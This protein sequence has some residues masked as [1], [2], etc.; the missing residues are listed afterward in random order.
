LRISKIIARGK[1]IFV[2]SDLHIGDGTAKD[3][4]YFRKKHLLLQSFLDYVDGE[5][6]ELVIIGDFLELWHYSLESVV[7]RYGGLFDQLWEMNTHY[8]PGN[9]DES[10]MSAHAGRE[11]HHPFFNSMVCPFVRTIGGRRFKFMHGHEIDPFTGSRMEN[12]ARLFK[13]FTHLLEPMSDCICFS[14]DALVEAALELGECFLVLKKWFRNRLS[15]AMEQCCSA[16][17]NSKLA[18]LRRGLRTYNMLRRHDEERM[19]GLYDIAI[20]GHTHKAG[21]FDDWYFNS[22]SWTGRTNNFLR[23][24]PDGTVG[25]FDWGE[26]GPQVR[27]TTLMS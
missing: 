16:V 13:P 5:D 25:V 10:A 24:S 14:Q 7:S 2:I 21:R 12:S 8:V 18:I 11:P 26:D 4:F 23:I 22:G 19:R 6:G 3:N 1:S 20:V 9:H 17:P 15:I 27:T